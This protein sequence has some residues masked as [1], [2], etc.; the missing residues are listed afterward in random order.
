LDINLEKKKMELR[1]GKEKYENQL[2]VAKEAEQR[3]LKQA[4][5]DTQKVDVENALE[6]EK[7][8]KE[9]LFAQQEAELRLKNDCYTQ[10]VLKSMILDTTKDIYKNI[11]IKDMRVVNMG[12]ENGN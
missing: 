6:L 12:G 7:M 5:Y 11:S 2:A 8:R 3:K 1:A 4:R 9:Q 10:N